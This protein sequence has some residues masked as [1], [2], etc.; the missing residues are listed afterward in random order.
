MTGEETFRGSQKDDERGPSILSEHHASADGS[1][2]R[3][4]PGYCIARFPCKVN[5]NKMGRK[6]TFSALCDE[7]QR[8]RNLNFVNLN[9]FG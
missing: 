8:L 9:M 2:R 3:G 4:W 6:K 1:R 5:L 7:R